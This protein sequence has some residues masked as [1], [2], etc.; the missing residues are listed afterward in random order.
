M[1]VG[2]HSS[3]ACRIGFSSS[4]IPSGRTSCPFFCSAWMTSHSVFH[5]AST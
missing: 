4:W 5:S 3:I 2:F 1:I